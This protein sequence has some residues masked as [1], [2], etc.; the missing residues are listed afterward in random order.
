MTETLQAPVP[1]YVSFR[2]LLT[3][4]ERMEGEGV[5][6]KIDKYF[7]SNMA[8]G[9]QNHFR[10]ALRSLGLIEDDDRPTDILHSLASAPGRRKELLAEILRN[11][12]PKLVDLDLNASKTDFLDVLEEYGIKASDTQRK[13]LTFYVGAAE[14]AGIPVSNHVKSG[15]SPSGGG[16]RRTGPR[17]R[18]SSTGGG[19]G[20]SGAGGEQATPLPKSDDDMKHMYFQLL[21]KKA[22]T[23]QDPKELFDR[24]ERLVGVESPDEKQNRDRKTAGSTPATPTDPGS[25]VDG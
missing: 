19:A 16:A 4:I 10:H 2:T 1:P 5:P 8:G 23:A 20:D 3:Q 6:S 24:I 7:L 15:R 17:R 22:E 12:F 25:Q 18:A 21:V 9:T 14:Y 11:R 13:A